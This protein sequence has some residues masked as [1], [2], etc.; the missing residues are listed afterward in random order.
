MRCDVRRV[1]SSA[2]LLLV[3]ALAACSNAG[4]DLGFGAP[5]SGGLNVVVFF[6]RDN[7]L[8]F[9]GPPPSEDT[10][11]QGIRVRLL[12]G[13]SVPTLLTSDTTAPDGSVSFPNLESGTYRV[14]VDPQFLSDTIVATPVPPVVTVRAGDTPSTIAVG[15]A[16]PLVPIQQVRTALP[17]G[18]LVLLQ[19][20]IS[21]GRQNFSDTSAFLAD[22]SGPLRLQK[23]R[24][25]DGGTS[26]DPGDLVRVR[27]RIAVFRGQRVLDSAR[28]HFVQGT[29]PP[30][31]EVL[32]T[33][34]AASAVGGTKDAALV[35]IR[36]AVIQDSSTVAGSFQIRVDDGSGPLELR[37]DPQGDPVRTDFV[38]NSLIDATGV[39]VPTG[40]GSWQLWPRDGGDYLVHP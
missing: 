28:I 24:N 25:L 3:T 40:S 18:K 1:S 13:A 21:S 23:V 31:P 4:E 6:D 39:L 9:S 7:S 20:V 38:L 11:R 8:D 29:P 33:G 16:P 27:G 17:V 36:N 12:V 34:P 35:V 30:V 2:R 5:G 15:L 19:G 14:E 26:N 37:F 10:T 22:A 32:T